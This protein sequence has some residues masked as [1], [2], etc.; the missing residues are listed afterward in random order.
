MTI[1]KAFPMLVLLA[2]AAACSVRDATSPTQP[3]GYLPAFERASSVSHAPCTV[4]SALKSPVR[5]PVVGTAFGQ[6]MQDSKKRFYAFP[7]VVFTGAHR[8]VFAATSGV[9]TYY[10]KLGNDRA[11]IVIASSSG[12]QTLYGYLEK[13][14]IALNAKHQATVTANQRI[15]ISGNDGVLFE[16]STGS[17]RAAGMQ[18]NPC[19][20]GYSGASAIITV[21]PAQAAVYA[22]LH[23]LSLNGIALTPG[24][25]PSA[26]ASASPDVR[27]PATISVSN[28][29]KVATAKADLYEHSDVFDGYY[30][31]LCGNAVFQ[32]GNA[33]FT[34]EY[35][36]PYGE[37]SAEPSIPPIVFFRDAGAYGSDLTQTLPSTA[38]QA[39]PAPPPENDYDWKNPVFNQVGQRAYVW[40]WCKPGP[41]APQNPDVVNFASTDTSVVTASPAAL[42][43]PTSAPPASPWPPPARDDLTATGYGNAVVNVTDPDNCFYNGPITVHVNKPPT[44]APVPTP[45]PN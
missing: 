10:P 26:T 12:V 29:V 27:T 6:L 20:S 11:A 18:L 45:I 31:V 40:A 43:L 3:G 25:Y 35:S 37:P 4:G 44:P 39:C 17:V 7:G 42:T 33:R 8:T 24:P 22:R 9:A 16:Y 23:A 2:V 15:A 36:Y 38:D 32:T 19:G 28:V 5:T 34:Q 1:R 14:L 13:P 41:S 30:I 21:M